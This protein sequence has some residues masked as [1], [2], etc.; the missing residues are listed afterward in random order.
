MAGT[1]FAAQRLV[2]DPKTEA[3]LVGLF[4]L[5]DLAGE[6]RAHLSRLA[7]QTSGLTWAQLS[8]LRMLSLH[9]PQTVGTLARE[10]RRASHTMS[11]LI[12]G[13]ESQGLVTRVQES[14]DDRRRVRVGATSEGLQRARAFED[15][16]LDRL[17]ALIGAR[18]HAAVRRAG[19]A[20]IKLN[21][22]LDM[23]GAGS[24][25]DGR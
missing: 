3:Q 2:A 5:V 15:A 14:G 12:Q 1:Q 16:G 25:W 17:I 20:L 21:R 8:V 4:S 9:G 10:L 6:V 22:A 19:A 13:L 23:N 24:A 18:D 7:H 11:G